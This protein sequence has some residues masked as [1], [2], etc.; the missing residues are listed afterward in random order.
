MD[1]EKENQNFARKSFMFLTQT[2]RLNV[3]NWHLS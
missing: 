1:E 2:L 3:S